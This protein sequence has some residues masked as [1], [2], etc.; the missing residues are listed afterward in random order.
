MFLL[1][2]NPIMLES[3]PLTVFLYQVTGKFG[4]KIES[5]LKIFTF[6]QCCGAGA[7]GAE[8]I[9]ALEPEPE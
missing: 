8:I 3:V 6:F 5:S 4:Y 7:G 2:N 9:W 1:G